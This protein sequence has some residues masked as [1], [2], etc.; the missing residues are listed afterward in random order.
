MQFK[1]F[2]LTTFLLICQ[3]LS[4]Q[5]YKVDFRY[6]PYN[7]YTTICFPDDWQKTIDLAESG[8]NNMP[9]VHLFDAQDSNKN[10]QIEI[11]IA[12][13]SKTKDP[14][15]YVNALWIFSSRTPVL[16]HEIIS[17]KANSK[18]ELFIDC[19]QEPEVQIR[20]PRVDAMI[21]EIEGNNF[22]PTI[23]IM[24]KRDLKFEKKSGVLFSLGRP[25]LTSNPKPVSVQS[26]ENGLLLELPQNKKK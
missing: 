3:S 5:D 1:F 26:T 2:A 11:E 14:N 17:G 18:A 6:S 24:S 13:S 9:Q 19:G 20:G 7:Y 8:K 12:A 4:G 22:T 21:A 16:K 10:G 25:F 15:T 23:E